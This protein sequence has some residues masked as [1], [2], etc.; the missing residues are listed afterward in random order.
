MALIAFTTDPK[1]A[2]PL[3]HFHCHGPGGEIDG[4]RWKLD[5]VGVCH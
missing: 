2:P 1:H 5:A 3:L 4:A